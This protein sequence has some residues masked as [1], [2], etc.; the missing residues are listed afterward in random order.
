VSVRTWLE[1]AV[2]LILLVIALPVAI[3]LVGAP[4][5]MLVRLVVAIAQCLIGEWTVAGGDGTLYTGVLTRMA[6]GVSAPADEA[7]ATPKKPAPPA[8]GSVAL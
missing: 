7:P 4:I 2:L 3:L 1:D 8:R 6:A 5:V